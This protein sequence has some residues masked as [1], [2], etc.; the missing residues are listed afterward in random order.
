MKVEVVILK[1]STG[2]IFM[3]YTPKSKSLVTNFCKCLAHFDNFITDSLPEATDCGSQI[4]KF[5]VE[6]TG[7]GSRDN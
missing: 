7:N 3:L 1:K 5:I 6:A 2:S 4:R